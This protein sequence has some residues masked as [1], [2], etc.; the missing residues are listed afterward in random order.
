MRCAGDSCGVVAAVGGLI[1]GRGALG[2]AIERICEPRQSARPP[3]VSP[4]ARPAVGAAEIVVGVAL[5]VEALVAVPG[6]QERRPLSCPYAAAPMPATLVPKPMP[7]GE[8]TKLISWAHSAA[9]CDSRPTCSDLECCDLA[10]PVWKFR[11]IR[12]YLGDSSEICRCPLNFG[13]PFASK[14]MSKLTA[15]KKQI[16]ALQAQAE[17]IAKTEMSSA[18]AKV[19]DIMA[20]FNLTIEHLTQS[21]GGKRAAKVP[22]VPKVP[23]VKT[24]SV[25][26]YADP[27][28]G[29]TW[30]GFGR[31][32]GWIAGAKNREVFL[33][34][35]NAAAESAGSAPAAAKKATAKAAKSV[36]AVKK[37][38]NPAAKR[39]VAPAKKT[40]KGEAAREP[41]RKTAAAKKG[42]TKKSAPKSAAPKRAAVAPA[43][44]TAAPTA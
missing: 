11:D 35:K 5:P 27:K 40:G 2:A 28:T 17:R 1:G 22:K 37:T 21:A 12:L 18:I 23:K 32:P 25:A 24:A 34:G 31:A 29:R 44:P 20:E 8:A 10:Q 14:P 7:P 26:K 4:V 15:L 16:A 43:E 30:S 42:S 19:K 33:V 39:A 3:P 6:V 9:S 41:A 13:S 36:K 38:A